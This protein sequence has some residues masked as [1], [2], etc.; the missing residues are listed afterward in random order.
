MPSTAEIMVPRRSWGPPPRVGA[1][2]NIQLRDRLHTVVFPFGPYRCAGDGR[3]EISDQHAV[4]AE[5]AVKL[6]SLTL[7]PLVPVHIDMEHARDHLIELL[8]AFDGMP[9]LTR[10]SNPVRSNRMAPG[11][12]SDPE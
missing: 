7:K 6:R 12:S 5:D 8:L 3:K 1:V 9:A 4:G 10:E 2:P 11:F